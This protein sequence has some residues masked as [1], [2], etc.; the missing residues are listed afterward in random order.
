MQVVNAQTGFTT[1]SADDALVITENYTGAAGSQLNLTQVTQATNAEFTL[2]GLAISVQDNSV[3]DVLEGVTLEIDSLGETFVNID[4]DKEGTKENLQKFVDAYNDVMAKI[5]E[6][7]VVEEGET[8]GM[9]LAGEPFLGRL[10]TDLQEIVTQ[11]V[12]GLEGSFESLALIGI[13]TDTKSKLKIDSDDLDDALDQDINGVGDVFTF[14]TEGVTDALLEVVDRYIDGSESILE[15][16][17]E[18]FQDRVD[19][20]TDRIEDLEDRIATLKLQMTKRFTSMEQTMSALNQQSSAL[21][22]LVTGGAQK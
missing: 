18:A 3:A 16:R 22:G 13:T 7:M 2:D 14:A 21:L 5:K 17:E 1:D 9:K 19:D 4:K 6:Q 10:K 15:E 8:R 11:E 12:D 20:F